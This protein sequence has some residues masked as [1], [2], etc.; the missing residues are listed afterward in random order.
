MKSTIDR[1]KFLK[2]AG[3]GA[4]VSM[5]P[6]HILATSLGPLYNGVVD[7]G[8]EFTLLR[9]AEILPD[10]SFPHVRKFNTDTYTLNFK[11]YN[12]YQQQIVVDAGTFGIKRAGGSKPNF[13]VRSEREAAGDV[14]TEL[15]DT[16]TPVFMGNYV[17]SGQVTTAEDLLATPL[18]W[19]CE[20]KIV[21]KG[22]EEPYLNSGH[23]WKGSFSEG[24]I[25]YQS[26]DSKLKKDRID[27]EL[28]WKWGLMHTVQKM[29]EQSV[30]EVHFSA[31]DELDMVYEHQYAR[32]RKKQM[33]DCGRGPVE[34]TVIDVLGDGIIPTVYWV[35][36]KFRLCFI[37]T[38]VE[39]Y[40]IS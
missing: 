15:N 18:S 12:F 24:H 30:E 3:M 26:G 5:V 36:D 29:A 21:R 38:G 25:Y 33:V 14:I 32:F 4:A 39:A 35:D 10:Y 23:R 40:M 22:E 2:A 28:S 16:N 7:P 19:E 11:L 20:T 17:F 31:L 37:V 9:I 8:E 13:R 1:R 6:G 34:F 27:G